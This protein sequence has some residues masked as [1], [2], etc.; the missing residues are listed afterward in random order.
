MSSNHTFGFVRVAAAV[1][2]LKVGDIAFNTEE[3]QKQA[4]QAFSEGAAV[5]AFPELALTGYTI[6]DLFHQ[7]I[8]Q[9]ASVT[10]LQDL[11]K[12]LSASKG[13][14]IVGLPMVIDGKIFNIAAALSGG[15]I[16]GIVPK[17]YIPGYKEFYEKR[18]FAPA[19]DL[20]SKSI[21]LG[22]ID[23]PVGTD[24]L[25]RSAHDPACIVGIEICE[26]LWGPLPPSSYQAVAGATVIVNLSASNELVGKA[27]YRR[28]LVTGQSARTISGYIYTS[29]GVHEST[30]DLVFSGHALIA[31]DGSLLAETKR[32]SRESELIFADVDIAHCIEDRVRTTSFGDA[33]QQIEHKPFRQIDVEFPSFK[34]STD[35]RRPVSPSP[36]LSNNPETAKRAAEDIFSIQVGGLAKRIE[37]SGTK[38]ALLGLSGGLDSTLAFLVCLDTF[39]LLGRPREDIRV[40][41]MPGFGTTAGT[42]GNAHLLAEAAGVPLEEISI[43]EG[44]TQHFKDIGHDGTS[45]DVTFENV[46]ARLRTMILMN[47]SNQVGGLVVG[48]GDLSE[49]ALGWCTFTG[50]HISH[51][52][53][54]AGIPKT[55]VRHLV[56]WYMN[57]RADERMRSVL[58]DILD[59]PISPELVAPKEGQIVQK[60]EDIIGPYELHDFFLYHFLRW[61]SSPRKILFLA[62]HAFG[63]KYTEDTLKKWLTVF[64]KRFFGNQWKRSVMPDGPK[65][66]SVSL[67]PRGDWRMP[68]DAEITL[69]K[70][71]LEA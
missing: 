5:V 46:Q 54:N 34:D 49:L 6:G 24:L 37:H 17:T 62:S 3:I 9:Q 18:W 32:F 67:S 15:R 55:L 36:F 4:L 52:G 21:P 58:Q 64:I 43:V 8:V 59:T 39:D 50:D 65:V 27:A 41:T 10:A 29:C 71:D 2:R 57:E 1:P 61:G 66:G 56:A 16:I 35:L 30:T 69:W 63:Q 68:S 28:E 19:R 44:S 45:Q 11:A 20:V 7:D 42:R 40:I 33:T 26:D 51:Y 31:E 22:G 60:T 38:R 47:K 12:N 14:T 13:L 25:F 48:T 70:K 53:V 23:V